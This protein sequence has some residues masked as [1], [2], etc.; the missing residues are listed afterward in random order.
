M[1]RDQCMCC[2]KGTLECKLSDYLLNQGIY[3]TSGDVKCACLPVCTCTNPYKKIKMVLGNHHIHNPWAS[4]LIWWFACCEKHPVSFMTPNIHSE[5]SCCLISSAADRN[6][7]H[8]TM[9]FIEK[10][11]WELNS[12]PLDQLTQEFSDL[13]SQSCNLNVSV[14]YITRVFDP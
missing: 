10:K 1:S 4:C 11:Y 5:T 14:K 12:R 8:W 7:S 3:R 13:T 2:L 9:S 6:Y